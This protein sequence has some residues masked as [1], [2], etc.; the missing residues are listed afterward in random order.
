[1]TKDSVKFGLQLNIQKQVA[2][3]VGKVPFQLA[4]ERERENLSFQK[5]LSYRDTEGRSSGNVKTS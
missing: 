3:A 5:W 2:A 4:E 1:M